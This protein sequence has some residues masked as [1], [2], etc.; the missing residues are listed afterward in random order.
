MNSI[1]RK[2]FC[3]IA[4]LLLL[5]PVLNWL[6]LFKTIEDHFFESMLIGKLT[7]NKEININEIIPKGE[8]VCFFPPYTSSD[9][10][11]SLSKIQK[12]FLNVR[13]DSVVGADDVWWIVILSKD[14]VINIYKMTGGVISNFRESRCVKQKNSKLIL[15]SK[16]KYTVFFDLSERV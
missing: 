14:D 11:N 3:W 15:S 6:H 9:S 13:I 16:S 12:E 7:S 5:I 8:R 10:V 1:N 4:F 2:I